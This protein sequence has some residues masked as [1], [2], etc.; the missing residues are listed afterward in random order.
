MATYQQRSFQFLMQ[1]LSVTLQRSNAACILGTVQRSLGLDEIFIYGHFFDM[2]AD[3]R[4]DCEIYMI[5]L[6]FT[7]DFNNCT[8]FSLRIVKVIHKR[9]LYVGLRK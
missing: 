4:I 1:R 5:I 6:W 9:I 3:V 2:F 8:V 7:R